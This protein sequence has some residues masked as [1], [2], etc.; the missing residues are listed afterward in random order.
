MADINAHARY[1][2][3]YSFTV[4]FRLFFKKNVNYTVKFTVKYP[5]ILRMREQSVAGLLFYFRGLR[6][7]LGPAIFEVQWNWLKFGIQIVYTATN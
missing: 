7:R 1:M 6:R 4:H 3:L 5:K 2:N